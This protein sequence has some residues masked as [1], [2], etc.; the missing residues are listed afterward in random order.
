MWRKGQK[1]LLL[2]PKKLRRGLA[3]DLSMLKEELQPI[4]TI[5]VRSKNLNFEQNILSTK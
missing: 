2:R 5:D 3:Q 1:S 4:T